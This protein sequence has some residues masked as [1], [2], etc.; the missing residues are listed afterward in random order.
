MLFEL[1]SQPG[2][3]SSVGQ[4]YDLVSSVVHFA[5][6]QAPR[7]DAGAWLLCVQAPQPSHV[8]RFLSMNPPQGQSSERVHPCR[9]NRLV[10]DPG[11]AVALGR[12]NQ[13]LISPKKTAALTVLMEQAQ[14]D[15]ADEAASLMYTL[16]RVIAEDD[17]RKSH[18]RAMQN[19]SR[20]KPHPA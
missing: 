12:R 8:P 19:R 6:E 18:E 10:Q 13:E 14:G 2:L 7:E 5:S 16:E 4:N 1:F 9:F 3:A 15:I 17:F 20:R 11:F